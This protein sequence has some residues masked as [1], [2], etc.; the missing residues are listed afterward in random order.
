MRTL[1]ALRTCLAAACL[2]V[3]LWLPTDALAQAPKPESDELP[4]LLSAD[5]VRYDRE[6]GLITASGNVEIVRKDRVLLADT[7]TYNQRTEVLT[8][9]GNVS[10]TEPTGEVLFA[11]SVELTGDLKDGVIGDLRVILSD[12]ALFAANGA[13]RSGGNLL[14]MT[15]GVYSA[16]KIDPDDPG[17][18]PLWQVKAMK[19]LHDKKRQSIEYTDAW[20]EIGGF[21]VAYTP[22]L[23]HPD[24]T[25]R[26]RSG[27]LVPSF[28]G[29][30]DLGVTVKVPYFINLAPNV[31]ATVTPIYTSKEG[32]VAAA[33][34][35]HQFASASLEMDGSVT[36]GSNSDIR[37]HVR[38][39]FRMDVDDTWRIGADIDR[40]SDDTFQ[41]RYGFGSRDTLTTQLFAEGFRKRNYVS[42]NAYTFQGLR[43]ADDFGSTP[44]VFP[45]VD[46]NHVGEADRLGGRTNLD[47]NLMALTRTAGTDSRRLSMKAGWRLPYTSPA[48][49]VYALTASVK[50][51]LYHVSDVFRT[52][53]KTEFSGVTG[54]MVPEVALDWRYPFVR[55]EGPS[56]YQVVEPIASAIVS[57][58][59]GNPDTIP[60]EDSTDF[61]LD[62][63]NLFST[64]RFTGLDRVEGGQ[65]LN[66]GLRWGIFGSRGGN[67][68]VIVGQSYRPKTDDTFA[69]GSGLEDRFSDVVT[70]L[71]VTPGENLDLLYR[72]RFSKDNLAARRNELQA[73]VGPS[74]LRFSG[75]YVFFDRQEESE[76]TAREE[77]SASLF[78]QLTR[79]WRT[80]LSG[81]R[82]L[83]DDGGM[84]SAS[85]G[86]TF[87]NCCFVLDS[88]FSRSFFQDREIKPTDSI[89][90]RLTFKT[91]GDVQANV[92]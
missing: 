55:R 82:D 67:T 13:W 68:T 92:R 63:S 8:A 9:S 70:R 24:P 32:P 73:T 21:P 46:Y 11:D 37:G 47:L 25:V 85:F 17:S 91:L 15:R 34:Y 39:K 26:R 83:T 62:E 84:R 14:Q 69:S 41:R 27:F 29:S 18:D 65:R 44:I 45:M 61:E 77:V 6:I 56:V 3:V 33:E 36:Q 88:R 78:S 28:G 74:S 20:L 22:Y 66:Y 53:Q 90:L 23:S 52:P 42:V 50:G 54:R 81:V 51:D 2:G 16:C 31:D 71:Q 86:L 7:I 19:M 43:E 4:L 1:A 89:T 35:R 75:S 79:Y 12:S 48:G 76:F 40:T 64:N 10:L 58:W 60:N 49:D 72:A 5:E 80:S 38:G 30:T 57:P 59:G 87:E